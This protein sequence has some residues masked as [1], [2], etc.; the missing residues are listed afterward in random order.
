MLDELLSRFDDLAA[1]DDFF[2]VSAKCYRGLTQYFSQC[3]YDFEGQFHFAGDLAKLLDPFRGADVDPDEAA[4]TF[5]EL[6]DP[7][8]TPEVYGY[9]ALE[10]PDQPWITTF[11]AGT[12]LIW[13]DTRIVVKPMYD[14][15]D[16]ND[17]ML[18]QDAD[19][20][21]VWDFPI[22][23]IVGHRFDANGLIEYKIE[24]VRFLHP[25]DHEWVSPVNIRRPTIYQLY[26]RH[27]G[28]VIDEHWLQADEVEEEDVE[29]EDVGNSVEEDEDE[30]EDSE[31]ETD[32]DD[33]TGDYV[34]YST[35]LFRTFCLRG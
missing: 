30:E 35:R 28:I 24:Y 34:P 17:H 29:M 10:K 1:A 9:D 2:L 13:R 20:N 6:H 4:V 8:P 22:E 7:F 33:Q 31:D 26:N 16:D 25:D 5:A 27:H 11:L 23:R 21:T 3:L 12:A 14:H 18:P 15:G 32:D 19:G